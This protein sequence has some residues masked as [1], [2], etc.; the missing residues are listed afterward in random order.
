MKP[1]DIAGSYSTD[2][3]LAFALK[4]NAKGVTR[5]RFVPKRAFRSFPIPLATVRALESQ[6]LAVEVPA[7]WT[8]PSAL[9]VYAGM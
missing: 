9:Y 1:E 4:T 6:G 7:L 3:P 5:A 8:D 2:N